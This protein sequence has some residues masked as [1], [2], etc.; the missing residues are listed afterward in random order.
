MKFLVATGDIE[1]VVLKTVDFSLLSEFSVG[2]ALAY[3]VS[4]SP[5]IH[6]TGWLP[7]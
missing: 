6:S 5:S 4:F 7:K 1:A 2:I 3:S